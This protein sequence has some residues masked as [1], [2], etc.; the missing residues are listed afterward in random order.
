M[1]KR[2]I[3]TGLFDD[4]WFCDLKQEYKVFWIYYITKCD[5]A[6]ILKINE[7]LIEFHT[8]VKS[9]ETLIKDFG[10][11]LI[12]VSE[13]LLFCYKYIDFQ[14]PDFPKSNVKQQQSAEKILEKLGIWDIKNKQFTNSYQRLTKDFTK[15][16][17]NVNDNDNDNDSVNGNVN[18][19]FGK[20]ENILIVPEMLRIFK[21]H[22]P[23]YLS[24]ESKDYRP[25]FSIASYLCEVGKLSGS[26]DLHRDQVL[27]AWEPICKVIKADKFYSQ[28]SLVTISNHIQEILQI[29]LHGKSTDNKPNYGSKERAK[30]YDRLF[31]ERYGKG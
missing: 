3:D 19:T 26:P 21:N 5:H 17:V 12:R 15:S 22:N 25:L 4:E 31:A 2:F 6:G 30:E 16:Y 13:N 11:R 27:E 14:Y 29:S 20:S 10:N 28:K 24:S 18:E 8:G 7:R 9:L 1:A 23:N